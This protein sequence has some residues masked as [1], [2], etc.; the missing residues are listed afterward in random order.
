M[1]PGSNPT[2]C[3][4]SRQSAPTDDHSPVGRGNIHD[5]L[6]GPHRIYEIAEDEGRLM[7]VEPLRFHRV[8]RLHGQAFVSETFHG[9]NDA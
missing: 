3:S 9:G 2:P 8:C 1:T 4:G 7:L 6:K 5:V